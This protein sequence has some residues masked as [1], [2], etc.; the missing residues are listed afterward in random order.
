M[1]NRNPILVATLVLALVLPATA[2]AATD[3]AAAG[4]EVTE[5]LRQRLEVA[6][7]TRALHAGEHLL[8][9]RELLAEFYVARSYASLWLENGRPGAAAR[10]L[11]A[12]IR[13]ARAEG[14]RPEDYHLHALEKAFVRMQSA[15]ADVDARHQVDF[16]LLASD[17]FLALARDFANGKV[18]PVEI[19]AAWFLAPSHTDLLPHLDAA[20]ADNG[21]SVQSTL[22]A[23]LPED[24]AYAGT[25]G[26][27]WRMQRGLRTPDPGPWSKPARRCGP[28]TTAPACTR[29]L[30]G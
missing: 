11:L 16:E 3:R 1:R 4:H 14:L 2:G 10:Q 28:S 26:R 18:K 6:F 30:D 25:A 24:P 29:S 12:A 9:A 22:D 15:R 23:L 20:L 5:H 17:A 8:R 27:G 21:T 7:Q 13:G 19:D